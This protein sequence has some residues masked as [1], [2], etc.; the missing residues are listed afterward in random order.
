VEIRECV[1]KIKKAPEKV[2]FFDGFELVLSYLDTYRNNKFLFLYFILRLKCLCDWLYKVNE[3]LK[4]LAQK[5][6]L[7]YCLSYQT[8]TNLHRGFLYSL[9]AIIIALIQMKNQVYYRQNKKWKNK[10]LARKENGKCRL[11]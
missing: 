5:N 1:Y 8:K 6:T 10:T 4:I 9:C 2:S 11:F 3:S 7:C